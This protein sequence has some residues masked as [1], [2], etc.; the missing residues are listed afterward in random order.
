MIGMGI[1][2]AAF[3]TLQICLPTFFESDIAPLRFSSIHFGV[4]SFAKNFGYL[5][6]LV[7]GLKFCL[8]VWLTVS[9]FIGFLSKMPKSW[10]PRLEGTPL[11]KLILQVLKI[12]KSTL[13]ITFNTLFGLIRPFLVL[14]TLYESYDLN[15]L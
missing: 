2:C 13:R 8:A 15:Y 1:I 10:R 12:L 9:G 5:C 11:H 6:H 7:S 3:R 14:R 4:T